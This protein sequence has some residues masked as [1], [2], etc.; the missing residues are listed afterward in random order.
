MLQVVNEYQ[1][2][3][4]SAIA[5]AKARS[6]ETDMYLAAHAETQQ[7]HLELFQ[8]KSEFTLQKIMQ[9]FHS[10]A[11]KVSQSVEI[12][13]DKT[14]ILASKIAAVTIGLDA[15]L[16]RLAG[17]NSAVNELADTV[18]IIQATSTDTIHILEK[19][20]ELAGGLL[21]HMDA[22][23]SWFE[24]GLSNMGSF[25]LYFTAIFPLSLIFWARTISRMWA[26]FAAFAIALYLST[27]FVF[28]HSPFALGRTILASHPTLFSP[29]IWSVL[30]SITFGIILGE[31]AKYIYRC[32]F[33]TICVD[34]QLRLPIDEY[35]AVSGKV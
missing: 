1:A 5:L 28:V 8:D 13:N 15:P 31:A 20:A 30:T 12:A 16:Q 24:N 19:S 22:I 17:V 27:A 3:L 33:H 7:Y 4:N 18:Y 34:H 25:T 29:V 9:D 11:S 35:E 6:E 32:F 23:L 2:E 10:Y 21:N 14:A 26:P